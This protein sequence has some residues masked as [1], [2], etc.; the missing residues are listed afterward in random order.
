MT[1]AEPPLATASPLVVIA[2]LFV[3]GLLCMAVG[4][5]AETKGHSPWLFLFLSILLS[6]LF[7]LI[8]A[9][10]VEDRSNRSE[11][12]RRSGDVAEEV[13]KLGELKREGLL[14]EEE[15]AAAKSRVIGRDPV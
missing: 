11:T 10:L 14:N 1:V 4:N 2:V 13:S 6:P 9:L 7:G 15:F 3:Y 12:S 5:Y 8:I